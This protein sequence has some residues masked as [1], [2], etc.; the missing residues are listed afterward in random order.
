LGLRQ[1]ID[2]DHIS[3]IDNT[4][5]KSMNDRQGTDQPHPLAYG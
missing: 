5:R 3:A 2:G 4:T 1:A